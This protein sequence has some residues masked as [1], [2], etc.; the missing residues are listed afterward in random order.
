MTLIEIV[1][2]YIRGFDRHGTTDLP[3]GY[4][5]QSMEIK[6]GMK[7]DLSTI[8]IILFLTMFWLGMENYLDLLRS[9][10]DSCR[11]RRH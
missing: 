11:R 9:I 1:K 6:S 8:V 2:N 3:R 10:I 7:R 4:T 5:I